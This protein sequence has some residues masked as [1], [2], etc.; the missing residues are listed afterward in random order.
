R[1]PQ[2]TL[3]SALDGAGKMVEEADLRAAMDQKGLGTPATRAAIIEGLLREEYIHR[4]GRELIPTPKAFS[5]LFALKHFGV[6]ELS[7]P[8]LTGDW[9]YKLKQ[10]EQ[11]E[12]PR[13][14]F[15]D[16]IV[17]LPRE[18]VERI[19][20]GDIPDTAFAT[21]DAPCPKCGGTVQENYRK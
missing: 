15:M 5:L 17:P 16:H 12:L 10:M 9:E 21:V 18:L 19:R 6:E 2:A 7:S 8:E 13:E 11:G 14:E 20:N 3:L 4:N 1:C